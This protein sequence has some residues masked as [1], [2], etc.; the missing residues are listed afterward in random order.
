MTTNPCLVYI[1]DIQF[2]GHI[3]LSNRY[4]TDEE[5]HERFR[6]FSTLKSMKNRIYPISKGIDD[7][8]RIHPDRTYIDEDLYGWFIY[9]GYI[10]INDI[11][12][13]DLM[14]HVNLFEETG[15]D[16]KSK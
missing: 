3:I 2:K 4:E 13:G 10:Y 12:N 7:I 14:T 15:Y 16:K 8:Y 1:D 6:V 9:P 11:D 5:A